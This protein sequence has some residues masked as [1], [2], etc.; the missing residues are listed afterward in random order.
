M[1][2]TKRR[3]PI[4]G[5]TLDSKPETVANAKANAVLRRFQRYLKPAQR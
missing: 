1:K 2:D 5:W 3:C 4:T